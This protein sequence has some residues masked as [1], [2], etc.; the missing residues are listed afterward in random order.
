MDR[1][2]DSCVEF[3]APTLVAQGTLEALPKWLNLIP[4]VAQW[5]WLAIKYRSVTLPSCSN[6]AITSGGLVG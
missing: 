5:L 4:I 3:A 1:L 6:P 2:S